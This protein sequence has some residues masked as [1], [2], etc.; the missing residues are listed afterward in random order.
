MAA[1]LV[2]H[3]R[4]DVLIDTGFG[5][6]VDDD[7]ARMPWF[8]R[9][10]TSYTRGE[11]ARDTLARSG[12]DFTRLR[13]IL[14][15]HSHWDHASGLSDFPETPVWVTRAERAF[16]DEGGFLTAVAR[17]A[18]A[19]YEP[20]DFEG[21][22]YLGFP[23][24]H[25]VYGDGSIVIVPAPGHTPGSV[26]VFVS[27]PTGERYAF[28]GDLVWQLEGITEREERPLVQRTLGDDDP[29][30][31]REQ[32]LRVAALAA[33]FPELRI[34]PAHDAREKGRIPEL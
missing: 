9:A 11:A 2:R 3:P 17:S 7:F 10:S 19:R 6:D 31:V 30:E 26:I 23:A 14:L 8:F 4:G 24:S 16:I 18:Q 15:T 12:Y 21:G 29:A 20:Y 34:V 22:A 33:R 32:I 27:V 28:I 13:A 5:T 25:D 1:I